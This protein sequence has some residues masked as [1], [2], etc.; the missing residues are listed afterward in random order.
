[1]KRILFSLFAIA[2][3]SSLV[4]FAA[5]PIGAPKAGVNQGKFGLALEHSYTKMSLMREQ[6]GESD[7][8]DRL[9]LFLRVG[10]VDLNSSDASMDRIGPGPR[11]SITNEYDY[12][13][14]F[15]YG[16]GARITF[17]CV[18]NVMFGAVASYS[19]AEM[20][21]DFS[22]SYYSGSTKMAANDA[23]MEMKM[24]QIQLA[25]GATWN[26]TESIAV[27]GGGLM[28][29]VRIEEDRAWQRGGP[30]ATDHVIVKNDDGG[31]M[32]GGYL[33]AKIGITENLS[34]SVE[35]S[36]TGDS[37]GGSVSLGWNF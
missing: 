9:E 14:D 22:R 24:Q 23:E 12:D 33:G 36:Y 10:V 25:I 6:F 27:Y 13:T 29:H 7:R 20:D 30:H 16:G 35:G 28:H 31:S 5:D 15:I 26:A 34:L 8:Y 11:R 3:L 17:G 21:G 18:G 1:M 2:S 37:K 4:G 32:L 19:W